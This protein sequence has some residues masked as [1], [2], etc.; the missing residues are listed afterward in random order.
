MTGKDDMFPPQTPSKIIEYYGYFEEYTLKNLAR[1]C[2]ILVISNNYNYICQES[3]SMPNHDEMKKMVMDEM[4]QS[5]DEQIVPLVEKNYP[6]LND[7]ELEDKVAELE[8]LYEKEHEDLVKSTAVAAIKEL[9]MRVR[10]LSKELKALKKKYT[11]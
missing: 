11:V 6:H 7:D 9:K 3:F 5:F 8:D 2:A 10:G 4:K 1:K